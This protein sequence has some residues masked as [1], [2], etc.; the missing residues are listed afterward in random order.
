MGKCSNA[1]YAENMCVSMLG[2]SGFFLYQATL[3]VPFAI[4]TQRPPLQVIRDHLHLTFDRALG[5]VPLCLPCRDASTDM[6]HGLLGL[7]LD[8]S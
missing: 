5:M 7:P 1:L 6:Q 2:I 8:L 4:L 3:D